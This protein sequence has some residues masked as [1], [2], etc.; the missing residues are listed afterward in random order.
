MCPFDRAPP[1]REWIKSLTRPVPFGDLVIQSQLRHR[2]SFFGIQE[3]N[4]TQTD[5]AATL[6]YMQPRQ[7]SSSS[8]VVRTPRSFNHDS[9]I[10]P[11][12]RS[13]DSPQIPET[14]LSANH[15]PVVPPAIRNMLPSS[16]GPRVNRPANRRPLPAMFAITA[17][18]P[19][20]PAEPL[21]LPPGRELV[22]LNRRPGGIRFLYTEPS[23]SQRMRPRPAIAISRPIS[24]AP[25]TNRRRRSGAQSLFTKRD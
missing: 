12:S 14:N 2:F 8:N 19:P 7:S 20:P 10:S 13:V 11:R 17:S 21:P 23:P 1:Y 22:R 16:G 15:L 18:A 6:E 3:D 25:P 24:G 9:S 5:I 4:P